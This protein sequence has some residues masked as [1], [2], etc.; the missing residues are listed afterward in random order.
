MVFCTAL[1][2]APFEFILIGLTK[3]LI[4]KGCARHRLQMLTIPLAIIVNPQQ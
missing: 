1:C 3:C 2:S 4:G